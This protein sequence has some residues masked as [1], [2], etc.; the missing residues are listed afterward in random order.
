MEHLRHPDSH[1]RDGHRSGV[2]GGARGPWII[3]ALIALI[4]LLAVGMVGAMILWHG[5]SSGILAGSSAG[6]TAVPSESAITVA[7]IRSS[8]DYNHNGIDDYTD[9]VRGARAEAKVH[10][11]YDDGYYQ[12]GYPPE[13]RG[14]CT[15]LVEHAFRAA[16]FD[17]KAMVDADIASHPEHYPGLTRPDPNIDFRRSGTLDGF[18]GAYAIRLT[19]D[20]RPGDAANLAQWQPGDIVI[21]DH[22]KH[23]AVVSDRRDDRGVPY[24]IHNNRQKGDM[25]EDYLSRI[26][27]RTVTSHYRFDA[28]RI[29]A[30]VLRAWRG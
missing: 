26:H 14:A 10:P 6:S 29:P 11:T 15:D 8:S 13:G 30:D 7:N 19:N 24:L 22:T 28:S 17:L 3:A 1:S 21:F 16:G 23:I 2:C 12:G 5:R 4:L 9:I 27:R 18:F 20:I 25:E